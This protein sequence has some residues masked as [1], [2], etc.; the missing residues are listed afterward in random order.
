MR[1]PVLM[2]VRHSSISFPWSP[3][4]KMSC[5]PHLACSIWG[6]FSRRKS[7]TG[8]FCCK[9]KPLSSTRGLTSWGQFPVTWPPWSCLA[10][11]RS[12]TLPRFSGGAECCFFTTAHISTLSAAAIV[13]LYYTVTALQICKCKQKSSSRGPMTMDHDYGFLLPQDSQAGF[14]REAGSFDNWWHRPFNEFHRNVD[15][16]F[17]R[18]SEVVCVSHDVRRGETF[19]LLRPKWEEPHEKES[20]CGSLFS[21]AEFAV[22]EQ[23]CTEDRGWGYFLCG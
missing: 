14:W 4:R 17:D 3:L 8:A 21:Q 11:R 18:P 20:C 12:T 15:Q 13:V 23:Q 7:A 22:Q 16:S 6:W 5:Q 9:F 2:S 1:R 10:C 19:A